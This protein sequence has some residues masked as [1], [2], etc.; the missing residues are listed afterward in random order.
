MTRI[1]SGDPL[2]V[3]DCELQP[4]KVC[5][6]VQGTITPIKLLVTDK[7]S[8]LLRFLNALFQCGQNSS[9]IV[10]LNKILEAVPA[11]STSTLKVIIC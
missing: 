1:S 10:S 9:K 2:P 8:E 4:H 7:T 5:A 6:T 11:S 3:Q